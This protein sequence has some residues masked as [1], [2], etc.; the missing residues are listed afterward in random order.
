MS[1]CFA[2]VSF[3]ACTSVAPEELLQLCSWLILFP[4]SFPLFSLSKDFLSYILFPYVLAL[5]S[6]WA[7]VLP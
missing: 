3:F 6:F 7:P 2:L 4:F 1:S 5:N